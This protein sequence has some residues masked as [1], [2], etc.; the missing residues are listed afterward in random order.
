ML[1]SVFDDV[2]GGDEAA[3]LGWLQTHR[4]GLV[5]NTRRRCDPTY[6]VLHRASCPT[7]QSPAGR[8]SVAP[9]TGM[10]YVKAC[11]ATESDLDV[12]LLARQARGVTKRCALCAPPSMLS[13]IR[14]R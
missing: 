3:Y 2:R 9:F 8:T 7:I 11:A 5:V 14:R 13:P 1:V 12:W 10:A 4:D 6:A